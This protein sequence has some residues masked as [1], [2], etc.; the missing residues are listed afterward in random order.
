MRWRPVQPLPSNESPIGTLWKSDWNNW[1]PR[2]GFAWD[3]N[4]DGRSAVRGGYGIAY[5]R[6]FGNVTF[7]VLFNPPLYL[8]A[9]ID[10]PADV[11]TQP[12]YV[13]NGGPFTG[14]PGVTKTIPAGSLRHVDQNI[15]TAYSHIY[16]L[17][18]TRELA[19]RPDRVD[20]VQRVD[21][22]ESLRPRRRQQARRCAD[23][24]RHRHRNVASE[25]A[26]A[27]FNTRGNR[28]ESQYH[29]VVFSLD[30]R[31]VARAD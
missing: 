1:A 23:L 30:A 31:E 14:T 29:G 25:H 6:N 13:D 18:Y 4:G 27:A 26:Y 9:T 21:R 8:V 15:K 12:I 16:G 19:G 5:E 22:S 10:S 24:H 3:V 20:R 11:A 7:N 2:I 28:G 17:S